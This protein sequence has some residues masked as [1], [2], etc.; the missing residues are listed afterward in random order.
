[1][2]IIWQPALNALN[3]QMLS[4]TLRI[5]PEVVQS[6]SAQ[7]AS[8]GFPFFHH[9]IVHALMKDVARTS[10]PIAGIPLRGQQSS[11][12]SRNSIPPGLVPCAIES[13]HASF[14]A[15]ETYNLGITLVPRFAPPA[16]SI[17]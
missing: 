11:L 12:V 13:G 8:T 3:L 1:M 10:A 14:N 7:I 15:G 9:T 2:S 16:A 5:R 17:A 6:D 4:F